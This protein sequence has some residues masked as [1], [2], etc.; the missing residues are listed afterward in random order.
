MTRAGLTLV[1]TVAFSISS[2]LY[3]LAGTAPFFMTMFLQVVTFAGIY[4]KLGDIMNL[5]AL[6]SNESQSMGRQLLRRPRMFMTRQSRRL[7]RTMRQVVRGSTC[8]TTSK[9][10]SNGVQPKSNS[11]T[12]E[13]GNQSR[14]NPT[15]Q[16]THSD[17]QPNNLG[18][19]A[20]ATVGNVLDTK[21][22]ALNKA[23]E[24][25]D[26]IKDAPTNAK[27]ALY[28]GQRELKCVTQLIFHQP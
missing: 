1:I 2:M 17:N 3:S 24:L 26:T 7:Q 22:R 23:T 9:A 4:F 20:G 8:Q 11:A 16:P 27:Y 14:R 18:V 10:A 21:N 19:K 12:H 5:F 13:R 25:K 28:K 15:T 6:Q